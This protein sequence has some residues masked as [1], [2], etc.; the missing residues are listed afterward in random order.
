M[1]IEGEEVT[2]PPL[3]QYREYLHLLAPLQLAALLGCDALE[4]RPDTRKSPFDFGFA[5]HDVPGSD[6]TDGELRLTRHTDLAHEHHI[7]RGAE[8]ACDL[9]RDGDPAAR[10]REDEHGR[11]QLVLLQLTRERGTR[12]RTIGKHPGSERHTDAQTILSSA[13][14]VRWRSPKASLCLGREEAGHHGRDAQ[15]RDD[16]HVFRCDHRAEAAPGRRAASPERRPQS[17]PV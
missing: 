3:E 9:M 8:R 6:G 15:D 5:H 1:A 12:R 16:Q 13:I 4:S 7:E 10:Q 2:Q 17:P 11:G 14:D